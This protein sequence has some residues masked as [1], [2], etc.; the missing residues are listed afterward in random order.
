MPSYSVTLLLLITHV[1]QTIWSISTVS[2][3]ALFSLLPAVTRVTLLLKQYG[4]Y[5]QFL[6]MLYFIFYLRL[7]VLP[8]YPNN[9]VK[10]YSFYLCPLTLTKT[11]WSVLTVLW[12]LSYSYPV[13]CSYPY[14]PVSQTVFMVSHI[15]FFKTFY[16]EPDLWFDYFVGYTV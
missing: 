13:S 9:M 7:P 5:L 8:C 12:I 2:I 4:Q 1:T 15:F 14:Y 11:R 16:N 6:L 10:I 3:N